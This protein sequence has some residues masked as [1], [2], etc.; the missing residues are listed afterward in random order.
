[1][2]ITL[3]S[4]TPRS[5]SLLFLC[6]TLA[7]AEASVWRRMG[8][9]ISDKGQVVDWELGAAGRGDQSAGVKEQSELDSPLESEL[10]LKNKAPNYNLASNNNSPVAAAL[11]ADSVRG[12]L[13]SATQSWPSDAMEQACRKD[14]PKLNSTPT[15]GDRAKQKSAQQEAKQR[16]R[17]EIYALNKVM[18][19]LEQQQFEAFCKQM[20]SQ[21]E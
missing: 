16:Q 19:E 18:T 4:L 17:A 2:T 11:L 12:P 13:A 5:S 3:I 14:R 6:P 21:G 10:N 8:S 20:Q 1:T 9:L 7:D 15:R